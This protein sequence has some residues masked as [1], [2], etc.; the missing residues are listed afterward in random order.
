MFEII[1]FK[2]LILDNINY[3]TS[4]KV[5]DK[6][7]IPLSYKNSQ[8]L[9]IQLP[10]LY[11]DNLVNKLMIL[12]LISKSNKISQ[13]IVSFFDKLENKF[14]DDLKNIIKKNKQKLSNNNKFTYNRLLYI[15]S[16]NEPK[17][18]GLKLNTDNVKIF[19]KNHELISSDN[20]RSLIGTYINSIVE[21]NSIIISNE[22][23]FIN[24]KLHQIKL[25]SPPIRKL[26]LT[27]YSFNSDSDDDSH[28]FSTYSENY[29]NV[30]DV[31]ANSDFRIDICDDNNVVINKKFDLD[32]EKNDLSEKPIV[33]DNI[34]LN[35]DQFE[36]T[37][38]DLDKIDDLDKLNDI[39]SSEHSELNDY[40]DN[41]K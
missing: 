3:E 2:Q 12:S 14:T 20:I 11:F 10:P 33:K 38:N 25:T 29:D 40:L 21:L 23:I 18:Y 24:I 39:D 15:I 32:K 8:P 28:D 9:F 22:N 1:K 30:K 35:N 34:K 5:Q 17:V 16:N 26:F 37:Q 27:E 31:I 7:I 6:L 41:L 13:N 36:K 19:N 4:F